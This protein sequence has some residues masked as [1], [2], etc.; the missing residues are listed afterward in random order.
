MIDIEL[1]I[2]PKEA[3]KKAKTQ[4][5]NKKG[6]FVGNEK[7]G[8]FSITVPMFRMVKGNYTIENNVFKL[9]I[10]EKSKFLKDALIKSTL[11]SYLN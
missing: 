9:N 2:E 5:E 1:K 8:S 4:I 11:E 10:T 6:S 7:F 3:V